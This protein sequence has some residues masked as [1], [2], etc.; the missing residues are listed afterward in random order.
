MKIPFMVSAKGYNKKYLQRD[1]VAGLVVT[2]VAVPELMGIATM[3]GVPV[4]M[5]LYSAILA[6]IIFALFGVSRRLIVGADSATAVLLAGGA[7]ALAVAGSPQ[8]I[9]LVLTIGVM[10][11]LM[12]ALIT[13]FKLTF[14]ADLISRPVMIGFLAGIGL[15]LMITKLPE[16][17]GVH[18][19]GSPLAVVAQLPSHGTAINGMA[20][21]IAVLVV[22]LFVILRSSRIPA[23]LVGLVAAAGVALLFDMQKSGVTMVGALPHGLPHITPPT[24][25][26]DSLLGL[27]PVAFSVALVILAQSAAVIRSNADEHD[28]KPDVNRDMLALSAAGITSALTSGLAINGSPPRTLVADLAGMRSQVASVVMSILVVLLLLFGGTMFTSVPTAAL[29]AIVFMMGLHLIKFRELGYLLRHHRMESAIALIAA[30]SVVVF[31][32]FN[33]IVIAVT[34][35]LMERLRREYHPTSE[36]LLRDGRLS[37]WATE[38]VV[39]LADIP[40][41]MLVFGFDASLFFENS[42]YFGHCLRRAV[43]GAKNPL[44][45]VIIDTSAMDD[46]DYTAVEQLKTAYRHLSTDGVRL[47]FSHVSPSL[48]RQFEQY[49]VVDLVGSK[50]IFSTLR[51]AIEYRPGEQHSVSARVA[52]LKL[53]EGSYVV[54]GGAVMEVLNLRDSHD[55]DIVVD[56]DTYARYTDDPTWHEY[57]LVSGKVIVSKNG[58]NL[59]R[60]W[61]GH[62]L[63][64]IVRKDTFSKDGVVFMGPKQLI[65]YK[66]HL[67][68][69]KDQADIALLRSQQVRQRS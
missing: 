55:I 50:N 41:D 13:V 42:Q 17:L 24:I 59:M 49:G 32:V 66:S 5:G 2:A 35:S 62:T 39:G 11:A 31:G 37:A 27:L 45:T 14:L 15:Q 20:L 68:R 21:T 25:A 40:N 43:R 54:V 7:G 9:Q 69:R 30:V 44:R 4:Q 22:G 48:L 52:A 64:T 6:P 19:H 3:A 18:I 26:M 58:I 28:E 61:I 29:A 65:E 56:H 57:T 51:A 8:Y 10:S 12:L 16:M 36:V 38:R 1:I 23:A 46:I 67:G 63:P 34:A 47:G 33:S 53:P 60:S